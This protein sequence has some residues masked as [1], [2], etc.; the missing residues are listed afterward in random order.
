MDGLI[1][2]YQFHYQILKD[3]LGED[4]NLI[5]AAVQPRVTG[6][7]VTASQNESENATDYIYKAYSECMK[8][9]SRKISCLLKD[10]VDYGSDAY[11][12]IINQEDIGKRQ[13]TTDIKFL[14]TQYE[15]EKFEAMMNMSIQ[16][17]QDL[18][19]FINPFQLMQI[20]KEDVKMAW[21][22]FNRGQ[23]KMLLYEEA[24]AK[25]NQDAT[26]QAQ[27]ESGKQIEQ[28]KRKSM[29]AE[30]QMKGQIENMV[31]KEKQKEIILSGIFGVYQKGIP[32]PPELKGLEAEM[33]KNV[34][35]PLFAENAANIAAIS[36]MAQGDEQETGQPQ[37]QPEENQ[38]QMQ[39]QTNQP[40]VAA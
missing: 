5:T 21:A 6:E 38:E 14:P 30:V 33:I 27:V 40:Q 23:K 22:F 26:F 8:I 35:I 32:M 15:M 13:F 36:D 3:E 10:S 2:D 20:A 12:K 39:Q 37:E 11:R 19:K 24:M 25:Q 17:N 28:E 34:A 4:P 7:N 1:K 18:I 16:A 31:S 9:T 29:T